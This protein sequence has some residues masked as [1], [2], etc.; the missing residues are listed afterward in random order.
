MCGRYRLTAEEGYIRDHFGLEDV[1]RA[2]VLA[3]PVSQR[4][5]PRDYADPEDTQK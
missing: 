5:S 4:S 2:P 3:R 1:S